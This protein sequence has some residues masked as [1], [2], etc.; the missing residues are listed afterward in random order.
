MIRISLG[1]NVRTLW[2]WV[3][4]ALLLEAN[5]L[6]DQNDVLVRKGRSPYKHLGSLRYFCAFCIHDF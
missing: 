4:G 1:Q 5:L 3:V 6:K 2:S